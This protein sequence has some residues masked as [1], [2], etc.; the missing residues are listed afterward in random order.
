MNRR[1]VI[2]NR[3]FYWQEEDGRLSPVRITERIIAQLRQ[4]S[5]QTQ[6]AHQQDN[7]HA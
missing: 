4:A 7:T 5:Y 3:R 2:H 1:A 6:I